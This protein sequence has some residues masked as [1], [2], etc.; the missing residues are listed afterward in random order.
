[1]RV[2]SKIG[3]KFAHFLTPVKIRE[4]VETSEIFSCHTYVLSAGIGF[5]YLVA[6]GRL[7]TLR[8][9]D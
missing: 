9:G 1:M 2:G 8:A 4:L 3:E 7:V 6:I 5:F